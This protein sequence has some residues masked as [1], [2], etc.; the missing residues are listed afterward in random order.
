MYL[1]LVR[2]ERCCKLDVFMVHRFSG[3]AEVT[4]FAFCFLSTLVLL[5]PHFQHNNV[6]VF[7]RHLCHDI[8]FFGSVQLNAT[9]SGLKHQKEK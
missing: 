7:K 6:L 8:L 5:C 4:G 9:T 2:C 1:I 3:I